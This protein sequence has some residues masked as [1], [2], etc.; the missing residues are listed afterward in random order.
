MDSRYCFGR[1]SSRREFILERGLLPHWRTFVGWITCPAPSQLVSSFIC[2]YIYLFLAR[3]QSLVLPFEIWWSLRA[4]NRGVSLTQCC[5]YMDNTLWCCCRE[6]IVDEC[7]LSFGSCSC[8]GCLQQNFWKSKMNIRDSKYE[9]AQLKATKSTATG[10]AADL[11]NRW[12][13]TA[14]VSATQTSKAVPEMHVN[15]HSTECCLV[16][17]FLGVCRVHWA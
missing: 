12:I 10:C 13:C 1:Q 3:R 11:G 2:L 5:I 7:W 16:H 6:E 9:L 14:V 4:A 17:F 15:G 8:F